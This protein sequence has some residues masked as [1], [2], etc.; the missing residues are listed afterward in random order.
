MH[1]GTRRKDG[2]FA[3]GVLH[4]WHPDSDRSSLIEN[5]RRLENIIASDRVRA[6]NGLSQLDGIGEA[7]GAFRAS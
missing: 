1:A 5:R 4:L 7:D 3:T 6:L 2:Q